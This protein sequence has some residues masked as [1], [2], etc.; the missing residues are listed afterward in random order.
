MLWGREVAEPGVSVVLGL[1]HSDQPGFYSC[2]S[3]TQVCDSVI[4]CLCLGTQVR[5]MKVL[6]VGVTFFVPSSPLWLHGAVPHLWL[7]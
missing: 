5:R 2:V 3:S 6:P 4:R 1:E 7:G